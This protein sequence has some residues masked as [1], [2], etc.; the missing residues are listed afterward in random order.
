M[1][2]NFG[3][4]DGELQGVKIITPFYAEDNRGYFIKSIEKDIFTAAGIDIDIYEDFESYSKRGV[5]RGMHFQTQK[6]QTKI[7]R[8]IKG[9]I[10]DV[11]VDLRKESESFGKVM[12]IELSEENHLSI[13][14]P[15]GFAHG[16]QVISEDAL[17]SYKCIGKYLKEYDTGILWNDKDLNIGWEV[18]N[19]IVSERD[20]KLMTFKHFAEEFG[21]I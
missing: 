12:Q 20:S 6:P 9:K 21:G 8:A 18:D 15:G 16:F 11:I 1:N 10:R 19:P 4:M 5:I 17:V 7:V 3:F 2:S 13:L 14:V